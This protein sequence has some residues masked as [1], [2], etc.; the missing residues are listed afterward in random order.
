M[1]H[2]A[3]PSCCLLAKSNMLTQEKTS[4][5]NDVLSRIACN[6]ALRGGLHVR[7][8]DQNGPFWEEIDHLLNPS[9]SRLDA[10]AY[11][12][13]YFLRGSRSWLVHTSPALFGGHYS[14]QGPEKY[15]AMETF[16]KSLQASMQARNKPQ[17]ATQGRDN[18]C[19]TTQQRHL[20]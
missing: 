12:S 2:N 14:M 10:I 1:C 17:V 18:V 6:T 3:F 9:G 13:I 11:I 19:S 8:T 5:Q 4:P 16:L 7:K 20:V 15:Q